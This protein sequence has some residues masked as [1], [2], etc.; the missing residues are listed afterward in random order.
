MERLTKDEL[1]ELAKEYADRMPALQTE[2]DLIFLSE[3]L[4]KY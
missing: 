3:T 2:A 4:R 1:G